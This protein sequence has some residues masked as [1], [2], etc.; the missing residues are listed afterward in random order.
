MS[1]SQGVLLAL[2]CVLC[3]RGALAADLSTW[4]K[5]EQSL[6]AS[7]GLSCSYSQASTVNGVTTVERFAAGENAGWSLVSIDGKPP[8]QSELNDYVKGIDQH[9]ADRPSPLVLAVANIVISDSVT[10]SQNP[11]GSIEYRFRLRPEKPELTELT[12]ALEGDAVVASGDV[13]AIRFNLTNTHPVPYSLTFKVISYRREFDFQWQPQWNAFF[14]T[15][16]STQVDGKLL[17]L[18]SVSVSAEVRYFDFEC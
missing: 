10:T 7:T 5:L 8:T 2:A 9:F 3:G 14:R 13:D 6:A 11:D 17:G 12:K 18:K 4:S 15:R 1:S 16:E